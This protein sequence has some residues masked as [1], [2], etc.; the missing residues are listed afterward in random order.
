MMVHMNRSRVEKD[1]DKDY[2]KEIPAPVAYL[3]A[4][5]V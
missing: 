4:I 5:L 3:R 1:Y 2:E